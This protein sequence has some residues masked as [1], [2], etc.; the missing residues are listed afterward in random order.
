[1]KRS[2]AAMSEEWRDVV[3]YE[4]LYQV[5]SEGRVKSL[6]RVVKRKDGRRR[7]QKGRFL[8]PSRDHC[9]Y[10]KICL[11]DANSKQKSFLVHRIVCQAFHENPW[12]KSEVNHINEDKSDNRSCN[13]EWCTR[14]ENCNHGTR[15]VR[16]AKKIAEIKSKPIAQYTLDGKLVKVW[17][18]PTEVHRQLGINQG[19][20]S[21]VAR[22]E[23]NKASG[24]IWKY[25]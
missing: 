13:L 16:M 25:V 5:S 9:G 8:K 19:N 2:L 6:E 24:F 21:A 15:N 20:I 1:M 10:K 7:L 23:R 14:K 4:G 17:P 12:N 3:G 22:G 11:T 18:S